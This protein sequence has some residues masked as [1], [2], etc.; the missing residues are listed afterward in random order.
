MAEATELEK[1]AEAYERRLRDARD[2]QEH[3]FA[4]LMALQDKRLDEGVTRHRE[5]V[6]EL[7]AQADGMLGAL[8]R[9]TKENEEL[10]A[11]AAEVLKEAHDSRAEM[12]MRMA[13]AN[14]A[15]ETFQRV[16]EDRNAKIA[17]LERRLYEAKRA[18]KPR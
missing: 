1:Q 7:R 8:G 6:E 15:K 4:R 14:Q 13:E 9:V 16:I 5:Q 11:R 2:Q 12:R 18:K 10:K 17:D 3:E